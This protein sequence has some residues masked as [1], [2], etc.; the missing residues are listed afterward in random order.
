MRL[1]VP[2]THV[3]YSKDR[4]HLPSIEK[5]CV[6]RAEEGRLLYTDC[7]SNF[8]GSGAQILRQTENGFRVLGIIS[9]VVKRNGLRRIAAVRTHSEE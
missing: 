2:L 8:G 6:V 9:G 5:G 1:S 7:D 4:P 3:S